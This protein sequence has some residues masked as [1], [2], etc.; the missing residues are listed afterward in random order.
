MPIVSSDNALRALVYA[1]NDGEFGEILRIL[2]KTAQ[3][4]Y[5]GRK[6]DPERAEFEIR[7]ILR[8]GRSTTDISGPGR[9]AMPTVLPSGVAEA[10]IDPNGFPQVLTV[11]KKDLVKALE[12]TG[13]P[14]FEVERADPHGRGRVHLLLT[15]L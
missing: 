10:V 7:G 2:P 9:D 15:R 8:L 6:A 1:G 3:S 12:R 5:G 4:Q 14:V 11:K 13:E